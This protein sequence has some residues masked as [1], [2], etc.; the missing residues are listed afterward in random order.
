M[1]IL[2]ALHKL[3]GILGNLVMST[4]GA[5]VLLWIISLFKKKE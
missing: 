3:N 1:I 4:I 5:V 2:K